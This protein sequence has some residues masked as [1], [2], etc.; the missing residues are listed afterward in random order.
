MTKE[1]YEKAKADI[2]NQHGAPE[3]DFDRSPLNESAKLLASLRGSY[4]RSQRKTAPKK[5]V[6]S[7][8]ANKTARSSEDE[9]HRKLKFV[10]PVKAEPELS[11][12][13]EEAQRIIYSYFTDR[14][15]NSY[16]I[17]QKAGVSR[18]RVTTF[19]NSPEYLS[20]EQLV[21]QEWAKSKLIDFMVNFD[22]LM[23][24]A[25]DT[26]RQKLLEELKSVAGLM[27][28]EK[29]A[30]PLPN[31]PALL[32]KIKEAADKLVLS[33]LQEGK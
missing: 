23:R 28:S 19:L 18:Q 15:L 10:C 32:A 25:P 26:T 8:L 33:E 29:E 31:D 5:A 4:L 9:G 27:G 6:D 30:S 22:D 3:L 7:E 13:P 1:D 12:F 17:A 21:Y 24:N 16:Q 14:G 2:V 11:K 20:F